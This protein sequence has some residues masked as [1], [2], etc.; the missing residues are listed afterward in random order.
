M[1]VERNISANVLKHLFGEKDS[2]GTRR[3]MEEVRLRPWLWLQR[4]GSNFVKPMAPYV[5]NSNE[6]HEFMELVFSIRAP[7]GY[8]A[9]FKKHVARRRLTAMKSHDHHVMIQQIL[10]A[11]VRNILLPGV[12]QTIIRLSKCFQKICMKVVN[13]DDI[14]SLK[15]YVA[16]TLSMLEMWF[17]PGFFDIMTRLLIN[18]VEDLDVCGPVG[19]RWCYPI[20]RFMAILKHY[21]RNKA[22]PEGCMAMGYMYDEALGFCTEYFSL[23]KHT[24]RRMWDP[25]E[26]LAD[27]GEVLQGR[28]RTKT[29]SNQELHLIHEYVLM[30]LVATQAL[31]R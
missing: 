7:T 15:V 11:C 25:E 21:V 19:A 16:E 18:L 1:H 20:E 17:P 29:L 13:P 23:Y 10:P 24:Q 22:K 30:N 14:P 5:F 4:R 28:P 8:V 6:T 31:I 9:V 2:L 3:D 26:E 12:R 27:V